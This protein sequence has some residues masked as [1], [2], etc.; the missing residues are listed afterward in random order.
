MKRVLC[1]AALCLVWSASQAVNYYVDSR[2][3]NDRNVGTSP[4][5]PWRTIGKVN[6]ATFG[7]GDSILFRRGGVWLATEALMPQ[8]SGAEGRPV[9]LSAY[10]E[11]ALP[12]IAGQGFTGAGVVSLRNQSHWVISDLELT[13]WAEEPGDRRGV[14]V[15]GANGG[16]LRGIHLKNLVIHHIKGIVG[17][18]RKAKRTAG[19]EFIVTHDKNVPTRFDDLSV[20]GCHLYAIENQGIVLNNEAFE[21]AN[22]PGDETWENRKFTDVVIRNNVIHDISKNA[23]IIRMTEGGVV[24]HNVCFLTAFMEHGGNTIFSRNVRGTVFQYNEGFLN[25]S[26]D[27]DGSLYDPDINSPKTVWRYSYSHD[28]SQG[29]AWFCTDR[30]DDGILVYDN[31]SEDDHGFLV[32]F[33][34]SFKEARVF[35]NLFYAGPSVRPYFLR[36]NRKNLHGFY[37][38]SGNVVWNDSPALTFEYPHEGT[39]N[40]KSK[41]EVKDNLFLG[42]PA[43]GEYRN[44]PVDLG[45]FRRFHR[46]FLRS[47]ALDTLVGNRIERFEPAR[48]PAG[49]VIGRVN[50]LPVY[51]HELERELARCRWEFAG[52][53]EKAARQ[54]AYRKA[55]G[56]VVLVKVQ[57]AEM[58]G[59]GMPEAAAAADIERLREKEN[60]FRRSTPKGE[61]MWFGPQEYGAGTF[62]N[63]FFAGAQE[64]LRKR[65]AEDTLSMTDAELRAYFALGHEPAWQKRGYDYALKA[66]R[67]SL[68]D[69]KYDDYFKEKAARA[70]VEMDRTVEKS[71]IK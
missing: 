14:E 70:T 41:G 15:K 32:Y 30:R 42:I 35:R 48:K 23:M 46:G 66:I 38:C 56:E 50:G 43:K 40:P 60:G 53:K 20:E 71:Y 67:T 26:P 17:Q 55:L 2:T 49:E 24:E 62:W 36:V 12:L 47:N 65:M 4:S 58:A 5:K 57:L 45:R 9:V 54:A 59:R 19:V 34:Y 28:N 7:P 33:N 25:R 31:V 18:G 6:A 64:E 52:M 11:G 3:G 37:S 51:R 61:V 1:A 13:N 10:G 16:V 8:G 29:M 39:V 44:E 63:V 69:K 27:H 21:N 68:L 22:Y